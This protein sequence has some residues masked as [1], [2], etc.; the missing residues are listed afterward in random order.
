MTV[1]P[2]ADGDDATHLRNTA[3][4]RANAIFPAFVIARS[5]SDVAI[6]A[7]TRN[8]IAASLRSSQ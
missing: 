6:Q 2:P 8:W 4:I 5:V 1:R 7:H 3:A